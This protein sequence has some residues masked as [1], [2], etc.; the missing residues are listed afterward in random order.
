MPISVA[1]K[2]QI[3]DNK[4]TKRSKVLFEV[5]MVAQLGKLFPVFQFKRTLVTVLQN[6]PLHPFLTQMNSV[7]MSHPAFRIIFH[8][9]LS[10]LY[11]FTCQMI[12]PIF[13]R[14]SH[15]L[16]TRP[17]ALPGFGGGGGARKCLNREN[18]G[19]LILFG[20]LLNTSVFRIEYTSNTSVIFGIFPSFF[21]ILFLSKSQGRGHMHG[22]ASSATIGVHVGLHA[23]FSSSPLI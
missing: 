23:P 4:V 5:L 2:P 9:V 6:P 19:Q 11:T 7:D 14:F 8:T 22:L 17:W 18:S 13:V 12:F 20:N 1:Q 15:L 16:T 21:Q 3:Q 10:S